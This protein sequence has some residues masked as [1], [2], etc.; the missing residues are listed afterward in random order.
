MSTKQ[1]KFEITELTIR[2]H[3]CPATKVNVLG[4]LTLMYPVDV[5]VF[6]VAITTVYVDYVFTTF[7]SGVILIIVS[8]VGLQIPFVKRKL[9]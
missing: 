2:V 1:F 8:T 5:K 7:V 6:T 3:Y 4:M 9:V